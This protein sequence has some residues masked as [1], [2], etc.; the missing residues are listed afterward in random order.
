VRNFFN[1]PSTIYNE[2]PVERPGF[3]GDSVH[4]YNDSG[5]LGGYGE[6]ECA[7]QTIGGVS[8]KLRMTDEFLMWLYVGTPGKL[9]AISQ[10]LLGVD[11]TRA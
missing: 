4:V 2:E 7:G 6:L 8:G 1:N 3:F 9:N 5:A 10:I 11:L